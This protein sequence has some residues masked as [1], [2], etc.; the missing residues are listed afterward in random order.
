[1]PDSKTI[2]LSYGTYN[3]GD[4]LVRLGKW[5]RAG[6]A[7]RP[8]DQGAVHR[9]PEEGN[10]SMPPQC[11]FLSSNVEPVGEV[12]VWENGALGDHWHPVRPTVE[13]LLH[14]MP[15]SENTER[16]LQ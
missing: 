11:A 8:D 3:D 7:S 6:P 14:A 4:L 15:A 1:M 16:K 5:V 12:L 2:H 10:V 13:L 9:C